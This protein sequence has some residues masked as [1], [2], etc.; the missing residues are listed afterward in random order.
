MFKNGDVSVFI[1]ENFSLLAEILQFVLYEMCGC[2][3]LIR[4]QVE[5]RVPLSNNIL[6]KE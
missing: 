1:N 6:Q 4:I 2:Q 5:Q 3:N